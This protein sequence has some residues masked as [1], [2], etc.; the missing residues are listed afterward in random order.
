MMTPSHLVG[1]CS[2][3]TTQYPCGKD[4]SMFR[5]RTFLVLL[6]I[7]AG[8]ARGQQRDLRDQYGSKSLEAAKLVHQAS[9]YIHAKKAKP[10]LEAAESAIK[11]E[12]TCQTAYFIKALA[13]HDLGE[14]EKAIETYKFLLS[15]KVSPRPQISAQGANNLAI[16]YAKLK[17]FDDANLWFTRAILEDP[18]N[19][20]GQRGKAYRNLAITLRNQGKHMAAA[21]SLAFALEDRAPN[22][23]PKMIRDYFDK[24]EGQEAASLM[25]FPDPLPKPGKRAQEAKLTPANLENGPAVPVTELLP[26]PQ[27]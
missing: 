16:T 17:E 12:P 11:E 18:T 14:V 26:D 19:R 22:I 25:H 23:T 13:L 6:L 10:A 8:L 20:F 15:D 21:L 7:P 5:P 1:K 3:E 27:G 24:A 2:S 9:E 4:A